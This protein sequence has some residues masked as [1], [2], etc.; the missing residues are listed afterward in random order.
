[1]QAI[2]FNLTMVVN[3]WF[4][5][6]GKLVQAYIFDETMETTE[7]AVSKSLPFDSERK[8]SSKERH[9]RCGEWPLRME[10]L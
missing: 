1:L 3:S 4:N 10:E 2:A 7:L 8:Y 5:M 6:L 9:S